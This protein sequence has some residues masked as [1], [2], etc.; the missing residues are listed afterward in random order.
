MKAAEDGTGGIGRV[1]TRAVAGAVGGVPTAGRRWLGEIIGRLLF[2]GWPSRRAL[3]IHWASRA[4]GLP[5][6]DR[7]TR[8]VA[9]RSFVN[10]TRFAME[11]VAGSR[12]QAHKYVEGLIEVKN[13]TIIDEIAH[14]KRGCL[15]LTGHIG[16]WELLGSWLAARAGPARRLHVV[17]LP[18][19]ADSFNE[20]TQGIRRAHGLRVVET[21][22]GAREI[23]RALRAGDWVAAL[24][25]RPVPDINQR[26]EF[27]GKPGRHPF[28]IARL[29][30]KVGVPI[31]MGA[32]WENGERSYEAEIW[33]LIDPADGCDD[34]SLL[35][36]VAGN[37]E[38]MVRRQPD[39]WY[40][41]YT[42]G[43]ELEL[44]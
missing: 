13:G 6:G 31:V 7:E 29:A 36:T 15:F 16:N 30:R 19:G 12:V 39:Q 1:L 11:F 35:E 28:G 37:L 34:E 18:L 38:S 32:C 22:G 5:E 26:V 10:F 43:S 14:R 23:L 24:V 9:R 20:L 21:A 42:S 27:L 40:I 41:A 17:V 2:I 4:L 3:A 44:R 25:D 8:R 33:P